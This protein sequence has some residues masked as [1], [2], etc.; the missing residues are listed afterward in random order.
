[1]GTPFFLLAGGLHHLVPLKKY[2]NY[3]LIKKYD[4]TAFIIAGSSTQLAGTIKQSAQ[5]NGMPAKRE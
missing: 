1:M 4:D 5:R 3:Q 2:E